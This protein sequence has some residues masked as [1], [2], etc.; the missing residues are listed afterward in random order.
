MSTPLPVPS[1]ASHFVPASRTRHRRFIALGR[2]ESRWHWLG[3]IEVVARERGK[4]E[5]R[6]GVAW[7]EGKRR[8]EEEE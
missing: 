1:L 7:I 5:G 8:E 6:K 2:K 3:V 4:V